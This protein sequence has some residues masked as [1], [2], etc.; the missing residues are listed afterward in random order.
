M[1]AGMAAAGCGTWVELV[2]QRSFIRRW[3]AMHERKAS[4]GQDRESV[5]ITL[6]HQPALKSTLARGTGALLRRFPIS[7]APYGPNACYLSALAQHVSYTRAHRLCCDH[8]YNMFMFMFASRIKAS[9][10][11]QSAVEGGRCCGA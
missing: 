11:N 7:G 10:R 1:L 6:T 8:Y 2:H 9:W 4:R 3:A 5:I